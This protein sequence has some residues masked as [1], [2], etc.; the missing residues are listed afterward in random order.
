VQRV[1][2][3]M[4]RAL[5]RPDSVVLNALGSRLA[6]EIAV[7]MNGGMFEMRSRVKKQKRFFT[8]VHESAKNKQNIHQ[9]K[10]YT[11]RNTIDQQQHTHT[12]TTTHNSRVD[13]GVQCA[14]KHHYT[15]RHLQL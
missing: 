13:K 4:A 9:P 10:I 7:G 6:F 15:Q 1:P 12:H 14:R 2:I 3:A 11:Y 8:H 5:L